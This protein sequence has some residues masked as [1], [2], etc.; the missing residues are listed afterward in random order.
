[1]TVLLWAAMVS[2]AVAAASGK[3]QNEVTLAGLRP[4]RDKLRTAT[5]IHGPHYRQMVPG[6][7]DV[8][9]WVDRVKRRVLKLELDKEGVI[10]SITVSA[11]DPIADQPTEDRKKNPDAPLPSVLL[12]TGRG[13]RI[14]HDRRTDVIHTYGEPN[15]A[16]PATQ[17]GWELELLYYQFDWAGSKVPQVMQVSCEKDTGKVV[18]ITLAYPSL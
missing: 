2:S 15:S 17:Y 18:Q 16:G 13:I 12:A 7:D 10:Q 9:V 8:V 14:A 6:S 5:N 11:I 3:R 1:M 4:G